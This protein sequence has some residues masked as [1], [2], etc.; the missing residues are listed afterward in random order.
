MGSSHD[1]VF[2]LVHLF[3]LN[4]SQD[5]AGSAL[6]FLDDVAMRC[7]LF[8]VPRVYRRNEGRIHF[9]RSRRGVIRMPLIVNVHFDDIW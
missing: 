8:K 9:Q 7:C 2:G 3:P 1:Q 6:P 4:F 5:K